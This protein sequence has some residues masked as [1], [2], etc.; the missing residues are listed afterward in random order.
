MNLNWL[1]RAFALAA[2]LAL[3]L[4]AAA[5]QPPVLESLEA[6]PPPPPG[7]EPNPALEPEVTI[8][9]RGEEQV[10]EYRIQGKLYMIRVTPRNAP[11]Y[12]LIDFQGNGQ[13]LRRDSPDPGFSPPM[14]VIHRF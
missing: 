7:L 14:W 2:A 11:P 3:S 10:E 13:F 1:G 6:P 9:Q 8:Y 4:P 12:Y 5:Q